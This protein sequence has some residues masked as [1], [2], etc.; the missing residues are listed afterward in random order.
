MAAM[1]DTRSDEAVARHTLR[2]GGRDARTGANTAG[3]ATPFAAHRPVVRT[4]DPPATLAALRQLM[5]LRSVAIA[6][7]AAAIALAVALG[8]DVPV[9]PLLVVVAALLAVNLRTRARIAR[10][11]P[12]THREIAA[13]LA[14]D[15]AAFTALILLAGGTANPFAL[16]FLLHVVL[17]AMLLPRRLAA[18]GTILV[19]ACCVLAWEF[20]QPLRHASGHTL[21]DAWLMLGF[22]AGVTLTAAMT[23]WFVV[24]V[25]ATLREHDRLLDEAARRALN[26]EAVL[27]LGT[28]AAGAAHELATPLTTMSV[29]AG[30]LRRAPATPEVARDAGILA[31]QIDACRHALDNLRAAATHARADGSQRDRLDRYLGSIVARFEAMRP[32]IPVAVRWEGPQPSPEIV[33]EPSLAQAILI[34]LNNAADASPHHVGVDGRWDGAALDLAVSDRGAGVAPGRLAELGRTFFTTKAPGQG[35]GLGLVLAASTVNRL[36][37]TLRWSNR[38]DGGLRAEMRLPLHNLR[39]VSPAQ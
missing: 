37:G 3:A 21:S 36:G 11:A 30:E 2:A 31:A 32:G 29:V 24:R 6:G 13:H 38:A 35:T 22:W 9:A 15:L 25:S 33:A 18:A 16:L 4:T 10:G 19:V 8:L 23:A 39:D 1:M 26:D 28:L 5:H 20:A 12:A 27:R 7:Q 17:I 14:L 34:L